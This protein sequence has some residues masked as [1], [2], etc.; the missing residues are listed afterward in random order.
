MRLGIS[1]SLQGL[2]PEEWGRT[3]REAG[4][5]SVVFPVD[6]TAPDSLIDDYVKAA[7]DNDL[8][9][10]EV[11]IWRNALSRNESERKK[12]LQYC[13][14]QLALAERVKANCCVNVAGSMGERWDGGYRENFS[15]DAFNKLVKMIKE[16]IDEVKPRNTYFTIEPMPW[17]YPDSP[18]CY[19]MLLESV[20]RGCFGV[21][22]DIVNMINC[23]ERYFFCDDFL[24]RTFGLLGKNIKSCH[25]KDIKLLDEYTFQL[26]ECP[27]GEGTL[28]IE[29]YVQLADR[30]NPDMPMIIEHLENDEA[31]FKSLKYVR[32]RLRIK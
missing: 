3:L 14:D 9:I 17:M 31:Y 32:E 21:H 28:N 18:E 25:L 11:G 24:E 13:I 16:V 27:C 19:H 26:R 7:A 10:A 30:Y 4:C 1:T 20:S 22:M 29:K 12:N 5:R 2:S 8:V 6:H 23:P 15:K